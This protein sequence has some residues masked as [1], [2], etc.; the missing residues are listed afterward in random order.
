M[1]S[2][3]HTRPAHVAASWMGS[4]AKLDVLAINQT[5][6]VVYPEALQ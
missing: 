2:L 3:L 5:R 6:V 1:R 4:T